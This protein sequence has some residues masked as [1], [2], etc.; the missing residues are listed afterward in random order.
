[1]VWELIIP[2]GNRSMDG[3]GISM[4]VVS[5]ELST[6]AHA[7]E[8]EDKVERAIQNLFP[9]GISEVNLKKQKLSGHHKDP[10][11]LI[12]T[13]IKKRREAALIL[14]SIIALLPPLDR[15]S[16]LEELEDRVD[17]S[18]NLYLR[19]DKQKAF[20]GSGALHDVDPIRIKFSFRVPHKRPALEYIESVLTSLIESEPPSSAEEPE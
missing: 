13:R 15:E 16:L 4:D 19:I 18:G 7:T 1:M 17:E 14:R 11:T 8:D 20:K 10:L 6:I 2:M 9:E 12:S 5:V 3:G